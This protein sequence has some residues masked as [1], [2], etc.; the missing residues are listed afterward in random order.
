MQQV[1][2]RPWQKTSSREK[3]KKK[4]ILTKNSIALGPTQVT[5]S[6]QG[7]QGDGTTRLW[8]WE[9]NQLWAHGR[10][11][12]YVSQEPLVDTPLTNSPT[13][14]LCSQM[15]RSPMPY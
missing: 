1:G 7:T 13:F 15:P 9:V 3:K 4:T 6:G 12:A 5:L 8:K 10:G 14:S 2:L 11:W